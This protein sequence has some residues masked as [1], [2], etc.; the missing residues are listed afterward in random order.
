ML[1][2]ATHWQAVLQVKTTQWRKHRKKLTT[3]SPVNNVT[4]SAVPP[5]TFYLPCLPKNQNNKTISYRKQCAVIKKV[6]TVTER[7]WTFS[8]IKADSITWTPN[9]WAFNDCSSASNCSQGKQH[10]NKCYRHRATVAS[11]AGGKRPH[12]IKAVIATGLLR[13][14]E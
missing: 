14:A 10:F 12:Q 4:W 3:I 11:F 9:R 13:G 5:P 8:I 2:A 6:L 1:L 7:E